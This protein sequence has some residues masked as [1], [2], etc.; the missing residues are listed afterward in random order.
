MKKRALPLTYLVVGIAAI[1]A[2]HLLFPGARIIAYPFNL[3][4]GIAVA[5]GVAFNVLASRDFKRRGAA[6]R[7]FAVTRT[8]VTDGLFR[9][10]RNPMYLGLVFVLTGIAYG[11]GTLTPWAVV[12]LF[13]VLMHVLFVRPEERMLRLRFSDQWRSYKARVPR[14]M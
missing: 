2:L 4:G 14:W 1:L 11:L 10:T 8:L 9:M 12:L 13:A 6:V 7:P 5:L 3:L